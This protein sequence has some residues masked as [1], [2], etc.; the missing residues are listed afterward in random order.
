[1]VLEQKIHSCYFFADTEKTD[2]FFIY[3]FAKEKT[4]SIFAATFKDRIN[5]VKYDVFCTRE[6]YLN[7]EVGEWLKPAVC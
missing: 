3:N 5:A 4:S 2:Y 1:M 6:R 7:G